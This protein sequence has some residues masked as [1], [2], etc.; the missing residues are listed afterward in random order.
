MLKSSY[1]AFCAL[2]LFFFFSIFCD[3]VIAVRCAFLSIFVVCCTTANRFG[4]KWLA[5]SLTGSSHRKRF[6]KNLRC[7]Y[8]GFWIVSCWSVFVENLLNPLTGSFPSFVFLFF[9]MYEALVV[10]RKRRREAG[11]HLRGGINQAKATIATV[12]LVDS[13]TERELL[14]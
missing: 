9:Q 10:R 3:K 5:L 4:L 11:C 7:P 13:I 8:R 14:V 2:S 1:L 6:F 12:L